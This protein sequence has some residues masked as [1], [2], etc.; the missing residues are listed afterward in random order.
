MLRG[1]G[2]GG[3]QSRSELEKRAAALRKWKARKGR[4]ATYGILLRAILDG[5]KVDQAELL[6]RSQLSGHPL[7]KVGTVVLKLRP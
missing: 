2:G 3:N 4:E 6:S 5:G 7:I 1:E